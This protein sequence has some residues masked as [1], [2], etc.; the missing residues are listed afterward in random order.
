MVKNITVKISILTALL[1][2]CYN[3]ENN[4]KIECNFLRPSECLD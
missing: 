4:H 2:K 3:N 1:S